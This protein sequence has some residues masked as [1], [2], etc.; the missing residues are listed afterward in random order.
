MGL[1]FIEQ[2]EAALAHPAPPPMNVRAPEPKPRPKQKFS[3]SR[4]SVALALLAIVGGLG[5]WSAAL[6]DW[7]GMFLHSFEVLFGAVTGAL[8]LEAA[9]K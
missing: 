4:L 1:F 6:E 9:T 8:G 2:A 7:S 5:L 3:W